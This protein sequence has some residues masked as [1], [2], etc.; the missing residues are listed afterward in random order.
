MRTGLAIAAAVAAAAT[1]GVA[2]TAL[3]DEAKGGKAPSLY[4]Q[5]DGNPNNMS[6]GEGIARFIGAVTLLALF[7]PPVE[8]PDAE[9]RKFGSEGV[10]ACSALID[11]AKAEGNVARRLPLILARAVHRVEALDYAGARADV[12]KARGEAAAAGL[13]GDIYFD[14]SFG[15]SLDRIE[16]AVMARQG[17]VNEAKAKLL[18]K[19]VAYP[20][21]L[22]VV[23]ATEDFIG[24][25]T[26]VTEAEIAWLRSLARVD[27]NQIWVLSARLQLAGRWREA[28][29]ADEGYLDYHGGLG[30]DERNTEYLTATAIAQHIAGNR[31]RARTLIADARRNFE[32]RKTRG[33]PE[34]DTSRIIEHFDLFEILELVDRGELTEARRRYAGRSEWVGITLAQ[35][36]HLNGLLRANAGPAELVGALATDP[37]EIRKKRRETRLAELLAQDKDN[38]TLFGKILPYADVGSFETMSGR[39]WKVEKSKMLG[40]ESPKAKGMFY[41]DCRP[42]AWQPCNDSM[43]LHAALL[44]KQKGKAGFTFWR[45]REQPFYGFVRFGNPGEPMMAPTQYFAAD[46]VIAELRRAIPSP[47][48]LEARKAARKAGG[49]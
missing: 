37:A 17:L 13:N 33:K 46:D 19:A 27:H 34:T 31:D 2:P 43:L 3:A 5:C 14:R 9:A 11:G 25:S 7:A 22:F 10:D 45:D 44:A 38:K 49:K 23:G 40:K 42:A 36:L 30:F 28:A 15:Q 12:D 48:E 1:N 26:D 39:V 29:E 24:L 32:D 20:N 35:S 6:A 21:S 47:A 4:L 16:A 18:E 8:A 41:I